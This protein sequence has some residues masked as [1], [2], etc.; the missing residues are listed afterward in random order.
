MT[1]DG[2]MHDRSCHAELPANKR[3]AVVFFYPPSLY[4]DKS[5]VGAYVLAF[6]SGEA[7]VQVTRSTSLMH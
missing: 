7:Y 3:Q 6:A 4:S 5:E 2:I 1:A